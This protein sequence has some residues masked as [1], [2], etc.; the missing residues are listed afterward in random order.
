MVVVMA[1]AL[2]ASNPLAGQ[3]GGQDQQ[4]AMEAY[5]RM[6]EVTQKHS[7]LKYFAG[8]W[9]VTT[10]GWMMPGG[11][12]SK[13]QGTIQGEL[14]LGGRFL[15]LKFLGTMFNQPFEGVQILGFDNLQ[16]KYVTFW[17]DNTSTAFFLLAGM[18]DEA[19]QTLADSG[20]W[21]DPMTGDTVKVRTTTK[22][23]GPDEFLYEMFMVG[24]DGSEFKSL[25]YRA[26]RKKG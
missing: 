2:I 12:A 9:D 19:N 26:Q 11:P 24:Q 23:L 16:Q 20:L 17:I 4:K 22:V 7:Y 14:I 3:A 8:N 21:P 15:V 5:M 13:S 18:R 6:M 25:E 1:L 10:T